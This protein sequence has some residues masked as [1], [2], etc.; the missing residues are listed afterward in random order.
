LHIPHV[1]ASDLEVKNGVFTGS[2]S[3]PL[4]YG[5]GKV[6]RATALLSQAG[7]HLQECVFYSDSVTDLPLLEAVGEPV[8]INPDPALKRV[9][10]RRGWRIE[11]W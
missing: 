11:H 4:C 2:P 6:T 8:A 3:L 9:A 7:I 1:L 5:E 10:R